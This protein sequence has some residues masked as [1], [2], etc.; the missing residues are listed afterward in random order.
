[1]DNASEITTGHNLEA[2]Q[3]E[4]QHEHT[5]FAEPLFNIGS[6]TVTN[7]IFNSWMVVIVLILVSL[8][9]KSKIKEIPR[10]L[11]NVFE[12]IIEWFLGIFDTITGSRARSLK[13]F[14]LVFSFFIFILISNWIGLLPG[15]GSIGKISMHEGHR[16]FIPFFRGGTA[17]FNTTLAL[18][19]IGVVFSH[20]F[21]VATVGIWKHINKFINI[22]A[23]IEIPK[24]VKKDSTVLF[25]NPI[26]VFVG[27]IEII[28]EFAKVASLSFRLFGNIYAGEVL[29]ASMAA[30]FAFG[31]PV[32]FIFLEVIV[33]LVQAL[34]FAMLILSYLV[35]MTSV[36]EH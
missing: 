17:D 32:P 5:L 18:A 25:V 13:F 9:V 35:M 26:N 7:S 28:G 34:I 15:I 4:V 27:F 11:Q 23:L 21:G 14:P 10:G 6:F 8:A 3:T 20:I 1:M 22:K 16:V 12:M 2:M 29:L 33:G 36:E 24:K 30:I 19:I 31:L